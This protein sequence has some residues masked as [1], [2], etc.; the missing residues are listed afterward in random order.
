[1]NTRAKG[2]LAETAVCEYLTRQGYRIIGRNVYV[3]RDEIDIVAETDTHIVFVEVKSLSS[4][5]YGR[6]A[7]A[8]TAI[9]QQHLV[10]AAKGYLRLHPSTKK[11]RID[12]VEVI[13]SESNGSTSYQLKHIPNAITDTK[14]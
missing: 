12:V 11:P 9:K 1:M 3:G 2:A 14:K 4:L 7:T 8:V 10:R 6:P 13:I 5:K